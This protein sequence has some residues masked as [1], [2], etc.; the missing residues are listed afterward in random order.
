[1][2]FRTRLRG[3]VVGVALC[4]VVGVS[5]CQAMS[6]ASPGEDGVYQRDH[7]IFEHQ[8]CVKTY[9]HEVM[10][11]D[12]PREFCIRIGLKSGTAFWRILSPDGQTAQGS[13]DAESGNAYHIHACVEGTPGDWQFVLD[14]TEASGE[15]EIAWYEP[16][17]TPAAAT[18][19]RGMC[20]CRDCLSGLAR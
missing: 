8:T 12:T 13:G 10:A 19:L 20:D 2:R 11:S 7:A 14:M 9:T 4:A 3:V 6:V 5:S 18:H 17:T 16:G 15:Y 1:M